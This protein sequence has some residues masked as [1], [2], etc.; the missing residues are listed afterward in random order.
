MF[1]LK[2]RKR[3][4][5]SLPLVYLMLCF[6]VSPLSHPSINSIIHTWH[7][8]ICSALT[9]PNTWEVPGAWCVGATSG[10]RQ[11]CL[12]N[13][14]YPWS[15]FHFTITLPISWPLSLPTHNIDYLWHNFKDRWLGLTVLR[16]VTLVAQL[17]FLESLFFFSWNMETTISTSRDCCKDYVTCYI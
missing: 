8:H 10:S 17:N 2:S 3:K 16:G 7:T 14:F 6:S 15:F 5:Q 13:L 4:R 9:K 11:S 12:R 1:F